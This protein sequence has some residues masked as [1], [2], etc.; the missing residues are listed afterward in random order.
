MKSDEQGDRRRF[1]SSENF[2][3]KIFSQEQKMQSR[4]HCK[5]IKGDDP[6]DEFTPL[7]PP[8]KLDVDFYDVSGDLIETLHSRFDAQLVGGD[9]RLPLLSPSEGDPFIVKIPDGCECHVEVKAQKAEPNVLPKATQKAHEEIRGKTVLSSLQIDFSHN[10]V[11]PN[12]LVVLAQLPRLFKDNNIEAAKKTVDNLLHGEAAQS[13]ERTGKDWLN[14]IHTSIDIMYPD[15][16]KVTGALKSIISHASKR[17]DDL[18]NELINMEFAGKELKTYKNDFETWID[19]LRKASQQHPTIELKRIVARPVYKSGNWELR[20]AFSGKVVYGKSVVTREFHNVVLPK[21]IIPSPHALLENLLGPSPFATANMNM[22]KTSPEELAQE[23]ACA[24]SKLSGNFH[25][26]GRAPL[27]SF[28]FPTPNEGTLNIAA[29]TSDKLIVDGSFS[30]EVT[31]AEIKLSLEE[32]SINQ[33]AGRLDTRV[34][35]LGI[36]ADEPDPKRSVIKECI[37]AAFL[38][39]W[40]HKTLELESQIDIHPESKLTSLDLLAGAIHPLAKGKSRLF[41]HLAPLELGGHLVFCTGRQPQSL[42][43]KKTELVF[44]SGI[45]LSTSSSLEDGRL[46]IRPH[47][48]EGA[49]KAKLKDTDEGSI[50]LDIE[51]NAVADVEA[52]APIEAFPELNIEDGLLKILAHGSFDFAGSLLISTPKGTLLEMDLKDSTARVI[53]DKCSFE[54]H[55]RCMLLPPSSRFWFKVSEGK[56]ATTGLGSG[57]VDFSWDLNGESPLL[58]TSTPENLNIYAD[59][60]KI[61]NTIQIFVPELR[62]GSFSLHISQVG[63]VQI[64]GRKKGLYNAHFFN[65]LLNPGAEPEKWLQ[66]LDDDDA[67]ERVLETIG[68]FS[69]ETQRFLRGT[70]KFVGRIRDFLDQEGI[71]EVKEFIPAD[72]MAGVMAKSI[73]ELAQTASFQ[74][75][76]SLQNNGFH[77]NDSKSKK[78]KDFDHLRAKLHEIILQVVEGK[79]LD[80]PRIKRIISHHIPEHDYEFEVDRGLRILGRILAPTEPLAPMTPGKESPLSQVPHYAALFKDIPTAKEIYKIT[81]AA[82][83]LS[84][85]F[86]EQV[87]RVA[88]YLSLE[89]V[90]FLL[91]ERSDWHPPHRRIL[92]TIRE[93][94]KRTR[95]ISEAYG[96]IAFAP[97]AWAISFFIGEATRIRQ[98]EGQGRESERQALEGSD[99]DSYELGLGLLGPEETAVLLQ[100]G[101]ASYWQGRT[102]QINGGLLIDYIHRQPKT[103]LGEVLVEMSAKCPRTLTNI[104]YALLQW[105]QCNLIEHLDMEAFLEERLEITVP[106][107]R[108]YLAGGRWA[109]ESHYEAVSKTASKILQKSE[110]YSALKEH[111][112]THRH[113]IPQ[114]A[115]ETGDEESLEHEARRSIEEAD[116]IGLKCNFTGKTR[117]NMNKAKQAYES[118]FAK[119][120][121]L[122]KHDRSAFQL[123]W[124]KKFWKRNYEALMVLSVVRN[125]QEKVDEVPRWLDQMI[126][127]QLLDDS[128]IDEQSLLDTVIEA[129]YHFEKDRKQL[130]EDPLVRLLI[131]PPE[132]PYN[133]TIISCMGVITEGAKGV[134]LKDAY[135]RLY[136]KR[137][138]KVIRADTR[139][140]RSLEFN[141]ARVEDA[142][143]RAN[144]EPETPWGY[145]GYSQGCANGLQAESRFMGGTPA[146]QKLVESLRCRNLLF[147]A[148][149]GSAHSTCGDMKFL[150]AMIDGDKFLKHYQAVLSRKAVESA[151]KNIRLLLDSRLFVHS[152]GGIHSLSHQGVRPLARDGQFR[153]DVPT[154]TMR[155]IVE[156][157][158]L[159]EALE[160]LS[161]MLTKQVQSVEHDTQVTTW[162]AVGYPV[163][164]RSP[165]AEIL[166]RCD[167]GCMVQR[168][169]HWSPLLYTIDFVTTKRDHQ[170]MVYHFPKDRHVFP[171]I[172]IN[173]RFG[174]IDKA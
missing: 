161:N 147:S 42:L 152:L 19:V 159:P 97:Q 95:L 38:G 113:T 51:G 163:W 78:K 2:L 22:D 103:F 134:E 8:A 5:L 170:Q 157:R 165:M 144:R 4:V 136:D 117:R 74:N 70:R 55:Q 148:L 40:P 149:N 137:G 162:E 122:I 123:P 155:G 86:S 64:R 173:A 9:Y 115:T 79:G 126:H 34:T 87:T 80:I 35:A 124:F 151:L 112:Q 135:Q 129:L 66:I 37:K 81:Q 33:L 69:T 110:A 36:D 128:V 143:T 102:P 58:C 84:L 99:K 174:N 140:A 167:I 52:T 142:L 127:K 14:R 76:T 164:V 169:H 154:T 82:R 15:A 73:L 20:I 108:D 17:A 94:K 85:A 116:K 29:N 118:A 101:L 104:L 41:F 172:E 1:E 31:P 88:P 50:Q 91:D 125:F 45:E 168:T 67:M 62:Q 25:V 130:K 65:A 109:R 146:Q 21:V 150:R 93:L 30:A 44:S 23:A 171:W 92:K 57:E 133:F 43:W 10:L 53:L 18:K 27:F 46:C 121:A 96:G 83:P 24:I 54:H 141:A 139:T 156:Q 56:L 77:K 32:L 120:A 131:D 28:S 26:E 61:K 75:K 106:R 71:G 100:S 105:D 60:A 119:C 153:S 90:S 89:Q 166:E 49:L 11:L 68:L 59:V 47:S 72:R 145:I 98:T 132:G 160:Y 107:L 13:I 111:L 63:G 12:V 16:Y 39:H 7:A 158:F 48:N 3:W 138:I 114:L 6:E